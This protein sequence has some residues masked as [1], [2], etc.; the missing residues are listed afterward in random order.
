MD[1]AVATAM[2][3][4]VAQP[5]SCGIGGGAFML[6]HLANGTVEVVDMREVAPAAATEGMFVGRPRDSVDG[7]KAI[8][9]PM[10]LKG[11]HLAWERHGSLPWARLLEDAVDLAGG[12]RVHPYLARALAYKADALRAFPALAGVYLDADGRPPAAGS[13]CCRNAA[14][15]RTLRR[16]AAE[17]PDAVYA[18][19]TVRMLAAEIR[20]AG[21]I[22]TERDLAEARPRVLGA[23]KA[24]AMGHTFLTVPPPS[25]AATVVSIFQ[26]LEAFGVPFASLGTLGY[27]WF[28]EAM[29]HAFAIRMNLGARRSAEAAASAGG[30]GGGLTQTTGTRRPGHPRPALCRGCGRRGGGHDVARVQRRAPGAHPRRRRAERDGVRGSVRRCGCDGRDGGLTKT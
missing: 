21:G 18:G 11:L 4:H 30:G 9:V 6:I 8:A 14:L 26:Q 17:G 19:E 1:A 16:V 7:G 5:V 23:L 22:V 13:F 24:T 29:K 20:A 27:H 25:S 15:Q 12:F 2:C 10:L 28:V 3:Q